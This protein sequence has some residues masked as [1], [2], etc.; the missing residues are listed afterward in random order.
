MKM[1]WHKKPVQ[2][3]QNNFYFNGN[4]NKITR[5]KNN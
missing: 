1:T 4:N 5:I 3:D 2:N